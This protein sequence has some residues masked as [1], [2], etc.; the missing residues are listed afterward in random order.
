VV[1]LNRSRWEHEKLDFEK[2]KILSIL[3][4]LPILEN[5]LTNVTCRSSKIVGITLDLEGNGVVQL[6]LHTNMADVSKAYAGR[7]TSHFANTPRAS[8]L[9]VGAW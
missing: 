1:W 4:S 8:P 7:D 2:K 6:F 5:R 9:T 3:P